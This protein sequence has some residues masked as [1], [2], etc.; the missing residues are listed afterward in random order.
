M[1]TSRTPVRK[2]K[3]P[4]W[5]RWWVLPVVQVLLFLTAA[6]VLPEGDDA[7]AVVAGAYLLLAAAV[8]VL[9]VV[10]R[11]RWR[12]QERRLAVAKAPKPDP[13]PAPNGPGPVGATTGLQE[14]TE[15]ATRPTTPAPAASPTC[16]SPRKPPAVALRRKPVPAFAVIDTET[17]G[18][19]P[20]KDRVV[21]LAI[22]NLRPDGS[23]EDTWST[24]F[25]PGRDLGPT[26]IHQIRGADVL[27][28]PAFADMA[29]DVVERLAGRVVV[30][31]NISF[32]T[33]FLAAEYAR[34]GLP[35]TLAHEHC[36]CTMKAAGHYLPGHGR[37]LGALCHALGIMNT[38]PH[39]ALGDALAT[40]EL[41]VRM[42]EPHGGLGV[43]TQ[44]Y[45]LHRFASCIEWPDVRP[46]GMPPFQ[47][48]HAQQSRQPYLERLVDVLPATPGDDA[49]QAYLALLDRVLVDRVIS[50][51]EENQLIE[52]AAD[53]GIDQKRAHQVHET[54]LL[55]L[56]DVA[57][58]DGILSA[59]ER[60]DIEK[61]AGLLGAART[62]VGRLLTSAKNESRASVAAPRHHFRLNPGDGVVFTGTLSRSREEYVEIASGAG[63]VPKQGVSRLVKLVVA[64]DVDSLSGKARAAA[65]RGIPIVTEDA[66]LR[67]LAEMAPPST[68]SV[69]PDGGS[70]ALCPA[71]SKP[72]TR[73]EEPVRAERAPL[74]PAPPQLIE[75]TCSQ[76]RRTW[77]R[78]S[79]PGRRPT[80]CP[81]CLPTRTK[82]ST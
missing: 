56:I 32:D 44:Q 54:Y 77:H 49:L 74:T 15:P 66:F 48:S 42:T 50:V 33:R 39:A 3:P 2:P 4:V 41:L 30:G 58:S 65:E 73:S 67:L 35:T 24:L 70:G 36:V 13:V 78:P 53:L 18:L 20:Q 63:L 21:E 79:Q 57:L 55:T 61:V 76:C 31:H 6:V 75:L 46:S 37:S 64:A 10:V 47:R 82:T 27:S 7:A 51:R 5:V 25:N 52:A 45:D 16:E 80:R 26:H 62:S 22:V 68:A 34:I 12:A 38:A 81:E 71:R 14:V 69:Q 8:T 29:G 11:H 59:E 23:A 28:A 17:T 43:L 72:D 1:S 40:A 19:F 9:W 60:S